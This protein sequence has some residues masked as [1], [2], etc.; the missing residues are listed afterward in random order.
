MKTQIVILTLLILTGCGD[1]GGGTNSVDNAQTFATPFTPDAMTPTPTPAPSATP[2]PTATA[3]PTPAPTATPSPTPYAFSGG[4]GTIGN[5]YELSNPND[6]RHIGDFPAAYFELTQTISFEFEPAFSPLPAFSGVLYGFNYTL[7]KM[8]ITG[9]GPKTALFTSVSGTIVEL[10]MSSLTVTGTQFAAS[11]AGDLTGNA[12][13]SQCEIS[14]TI[15]SP[16]GGN[17]FNT[18]TGTP[19]SVTKS[20]GTTYPGTTVDVEF[21]GNH[22]QVLQ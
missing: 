20:A 11:I 5:P 8:T 15:T 13:I 4:N 2:Q 22:V 16:S 14:G 6:V 18:G 3:T 21:N 19:L 9:S 7:Y 1:Q 10:K 17:G 12:L